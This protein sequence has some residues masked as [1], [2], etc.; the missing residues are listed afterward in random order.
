MSVYIRELLHDAYT[1]I[2]ISVEERCDIQLAVRQ[3]IA[4]GTISELHVRLAHLYFSGYSIIELE[5]MVPSASSMIITFLAALERQTKYRDET[6]IMTG[7]Q[8]Y[9]HLN[10]IAPSLFKQARRLS[11]QLEPL[12]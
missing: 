7:L 4:E 12:P 10:V 3:L 9:C 6:I 5:A 11:L 2:G 1:S 8:K